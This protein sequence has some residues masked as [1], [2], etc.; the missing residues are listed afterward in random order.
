MDL[1]RKREFLILYI[2]SENFLIQ[3]C[4][5][6]LAHT[7]RCKYS[8]TKHIHVVSMKY[9]FSLLPSNCSYATSV[10]L[11]NSVT[12][13]I[14]MFR[15]GRRMPKSTCYWKHSVWQVRIN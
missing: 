4:F 3:D 6:T 10:P 1:M 8:W 12:L 13:I 14:Y 15:S 9:S 2:T 11:F 7:L 5:P